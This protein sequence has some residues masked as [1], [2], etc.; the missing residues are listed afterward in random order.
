MAHRADHLAPHPPVGAG[1]EAGVEVH[2]A[3]GPAHLL[4]G[5]VDKGHGGRLPNRPVC[6]AGRQ[7]GLFRGVQ[8]VPL[9]E[10][11]VVLPLDGHVRDGAV[12]GPAVHI[13]VT[14]AVQGQVAEEARAVAGGHGHAVLNGLAEPLRRGQGGGPVH[15]HPLPPHPVGPDGVVEEQGIRAQ[16][17]QVEGRLLPSDASGQLPGQLLQDFIA[18]FQ[19][20]VII[21]HGCVIASL[22]IRRDLLATHIIAHRSRGGSGNFTIYRRKRPSRRPSRPFRLSGAGAGRAAAEAASSSASAMRAAWASTA[23]APSARGTGV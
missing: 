13:A 16:A 17:A 4:R 14:G 2:G 7:V 21:G 1:Q 6:R 23:G 10:H 19:V 22:C 12:G 9:H 15:A 3:V 18:K 11:A 8:A 5:G 20:R